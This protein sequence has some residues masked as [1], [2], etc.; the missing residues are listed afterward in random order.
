VRVAASESREDTRVL[1]ALVQS[2]AERNGFSRHSLQ[3]FE[4]CWDELVARG[5]GHPFLASYQGTPAAA[6]LVIVS[7][8]R[9]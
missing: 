7:G 1:H 4:A 6:T 3:Y 9:A 2:A 5:F 8:R